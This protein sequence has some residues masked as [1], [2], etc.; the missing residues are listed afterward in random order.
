MRRYY[1]GLKDGGK[2]ETFRSAETPTEGSH[3]RLYL[4]VIGPFKTRRGAEFMAEYGGGNPHLQ[5]VDDAER[6]ARRRAAE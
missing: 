4:A 2:R 6:I 5:C 3:G 1:V